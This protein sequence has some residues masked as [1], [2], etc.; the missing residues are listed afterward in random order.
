[1]HRQDEVS[2]P[3]LLWQLRAL[4]QDA[5]SEQIGLA[6]LP[7]PDDSEALTDVQYQCYFSAVGFLLHPPLPLCKSERTDLLLHIVTISVPLLITA[8]RWGPCVWP[9]QPWVKQCSVTSVQHVVHEHSSDEVTQTASQPYDYSILKS[10]QIESRI[11]IFWW[12]KREKPFVSEQISFPVKLRPSDFNFTSS[13]A[14][15]MKLL[16]AQMTCSDDVFCGVDKTSD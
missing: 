14:A 6:D 8:P 11:I 7:S 1:M 3:S 15:E 5:S 12:L 10:F 9:S 13:T 2:F 4:G 16:K